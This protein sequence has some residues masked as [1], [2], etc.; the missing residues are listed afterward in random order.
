M[1]A[2]PLR[3]S[4][5]QPFRTQP[6]TQGAAGVTAQDL[7]AS[8]LST[9]LRHILTAPGTVTRA[10][11]AASTGS[12]RATISRLV[13]ELVNADLVIESNATPSKQ[14]GRPAISL[15][16][17]PSSIIAL[18]LE[19]NVD[20]LKACVIDLAGNVLASTTQAHDSQSSPEQSLT[21]LGDIATQLLATF[22]DTPAIYIGS[23]L[24]LPGIIANNQLISAHN[25]GWSNLSSADIAQVLGELA[26]R[27]IANE[28]DLAAYQ[29][30]HP[31]PGVASSS[32]SFIYISGE[33]GVGA[34]IVLNH[35]QITGT[36]GWAGEIGHISTDP[37]GSLCSCGSRGCLET[38]LGRKALATRA[39]L[40][41]TTSPRQVLEAAR[42]GNTQ[43]YEALQQAAKSLAIALAATINILDI[44]DIILGGNL[45][46]LSPLLIELTGPELL[47]R[48]SQAR[49]VPPHM[50]VL[51]ESA[52]FTVHGAAYRVLEDFVTSPAL[53]LG[54]I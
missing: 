44:H 34:G 16:P 48:S 47:A 21:K 49:L 7:R 54:D 4:A 33:V 10:A 23:A 31:S 3:H 17:K 45:A 38:F 12:T 20:S 27:F 28:A 42:A 22:R 6:A 43:A 40:T 5:I 36:N 37:N 15:T 52:D 8:N 2:H 14:R 35:H 41:P 26:P 32:H 19:I 11:I 13:D 29:V 53:Y 46:D 51:P 39:G 18:G 50:T 9:V 24:A 1:R 25:L 30:A